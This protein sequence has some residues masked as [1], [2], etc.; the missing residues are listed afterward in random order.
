MPADYKSLS[1][2][3]RLATFLV[4]IGP[5]A[6]A[7]VLKEFDDESIEI[8]C[9]EMTNISAI[10]T[11]LQKA[12]VEEFSS[13][14][15]SSYGS[16]LGGPLYTRR[17]LEIAKGDFKATSILERIAPTSNSAEVIK[18]IEQM[19]PRQIFNMIKTEQAQT[20]AFVLSYLERDKAGPILGMFNHEVRE[21][22][23]ERLGIMEPTSL[24]LINKVANALSKNLDTKQKT[25]LNK[26][27]GIRMVADL[28]NT[29]EK[30]DSKSILTNIEER[31]PALGAEIRKK[32]F[33]FEDLSRLELPDLQ[34]IMR[35][36]DSGDLIIAL[37]SATDSLKEAVMDAVS[38]RA[39]ETLK[40]ELEMMGP[41]KLTEVEAAQERVIQVVRR[42]EEQEEIS[43]DGG[44]QTV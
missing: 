12:A 17:A 13:F 3:Q 43:L 27:G 11:D 18:E 20:I 9:K 24:E 14:I 37:K 28:L 16:L 41:V 42:L 36:V 38:K 15:L 32:M 26:S 40:E 5:E 25:T 2:V 35:E 19:E 21:E 10:E 4:V 33:S 29:L 1:R 8:I 7:H 22:V 30:E 6:A 34:R 23:I 44:G 31:N 39:A